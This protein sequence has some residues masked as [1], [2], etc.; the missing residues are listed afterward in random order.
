MHLANLIDD[1]LEGAR[2]LRQ[3]TAGMSHEQSLARPVAGKWSTLEV[4]CHLA[5]IDA[6]DA[7]RMKRIIA[8]DR[9]LLL[10]ADE[11]L[12]A[13][14]LA[15]QQRDLEDEVGLI[16][17]TRRQMGRILRTL[18]DEAL[19]RSADYRIGTRVEQRSLEQIL[20]KAIRHVRHHLP[21]IL[22]KRQA[23]GLA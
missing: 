12:F 19:S 1:Y 15:Y 4:A 6:L 16:E 2:R 21:F 14:A 20:E 18:P 23:L 10:D 22:Q 8:E 3:A 13:A 9:P 11:T 17:N 5:D 7:V